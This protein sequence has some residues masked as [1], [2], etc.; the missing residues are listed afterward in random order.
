VARAMEAEAKRSGTSTLMSRSRTSHGAQVAGTLVYMA[1]EYLKSATCSSKVDSFAVGLTMLAA[2]TGQPAEQPVVPRHA[3]ADVHA[4]LLD[5]FYEE[6]WDSPDELMQRLDPHTDAHGDAGS[7]DPHLQTVRSLHGLAK[8]CLEHTKGRRTDVGELV[9][10]LEAIRAAAEA[11]R[12]AGRSDFCCPLSLETMREPVVA[13]DGITYEK[14]Q[15]ERWLASN[16]TSPITGEALA[17]KHLIPN[18]T[19]KRLIDEQET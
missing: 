10:A 1:P 7:W 19:L 2:L 14:E 16:S 13:A 6:A 12:P 3:G 5:F 11:A 18:L 9:P 17:H 15:I 4:N 8:R